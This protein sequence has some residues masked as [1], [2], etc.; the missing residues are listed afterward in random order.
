MQDDDDIG[1]YRHDASDTMMAGAHAIGPELKSIRARVEHIIRHSRDGLT[2]WE[3][4]RI[5]VRLY[6]EKLY[7]TI[8]ARC[9]ELVID[10]RVRDSGR[11]RNGPSGVSNAVWEIVPKEEQL[12]LS[13]P[14]A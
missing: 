6:G 2:Q 13:L 14:A 12:S 10:G 9:R 1:Q 11:R 4:H 3:L 5:Y 8:G 7:R